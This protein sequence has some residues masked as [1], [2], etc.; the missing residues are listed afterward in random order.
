MRP[1]LRISPILA[2]SIFDE[3]LEVFLQREGDVV[4]WEISE[5]NSCG[6]L[7]IYLTDIAKEHALDGYY[8]DVEY[9][10]KQDAELKTIIDGQGHVIKVRC[11]LIL[12]SRGER[13]LE[14]N[15]IAVE[16]KKD[17]RPNRERDSDRLR[18]HAMTMPPRNLVLHRGRHTP[19]HVSGYRLGVFV[20]L[21]GRRRSCSVEYFVGGRQVE[22]VNRQFLR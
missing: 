19:E 3:A 7:A 22:R 2:R 9:N 17:R 15:L 12:H 16:M 1:Q 4:E 18:L 11:D 8:A 13:G 5:Q 10:R 20:L 21:C 14:D 6:R